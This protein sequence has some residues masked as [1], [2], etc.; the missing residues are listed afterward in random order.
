M[1]RRT[2]AGAAVLMLLAMS[3]SGC[4]F[5]A[6]EETPKEVDENPYT[7]I[8]ERHTLEWQTNDTMSYLLEPGLHHALEVQ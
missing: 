6:S 1:R 8:W 3:L 4:M 7:S 2:R 5:W